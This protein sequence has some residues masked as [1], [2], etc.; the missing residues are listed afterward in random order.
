MF[1]SDGLPLA[2]VD[3]QRLPFHSTL[4]YRLQIATG[5]QIS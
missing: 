4:L 1:E 5:T 3:A 2:F